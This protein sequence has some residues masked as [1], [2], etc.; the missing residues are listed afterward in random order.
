[1]DPT[2]FYTKLMPAPDW[3]YINPKIG[4][5]RDSGSKI[6]V[7]KVKTA[8]SLLKP[9]LSELLTEK[10]YEKLTFLFGLQ[11]VGI[12]DGQTIFSVNYGNTP[13]ERVLNFLTHLIRM[14]DETYRIVDSTK[15]E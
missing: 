5:D 2:Y 10:E 12:N 8:Y 14:N 11:L 3:G 1:M 7:D 15:P 6:R 4:G 9:R 13:K